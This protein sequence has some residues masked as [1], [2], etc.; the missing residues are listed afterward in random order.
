MCENSPR[1][2]QIASNKR[3]KIQISRRSM[4]LDLLVCHMLSTQMC[5]C[6]PPSSLVPRLFLIEPGYKARVG[7]GGKYASRARKEE[8]SLGT[9]LP[10]SPIIHPISFCPPPPWPKSWKK[11]WFIH[12]IWTGRHMITALVTWNKCRNRYQLWSTWQQ[13]WQ[14]VMISLIWNKQNPQC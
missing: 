6:P 3:S 7:G 5:T 11:P 13:H 9:R 14:I 10:P 1:F 8:M 2:Y 12:Q 4:P